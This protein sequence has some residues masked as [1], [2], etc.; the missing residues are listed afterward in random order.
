MKTRKILTTLLPSLLMSGHAMAAGI[1]V[2]VDVPD[3]RGDGD[4]GIPTINDFISQNPSSGLSA[5]DTFYNSTGGGNASNFG[6]NFG[7]GVVIGGFTVTT[8]HIDGL[9]N[10][11]TN[12][13]F[14]AGDTSHNDLNPITEGYAF[15]AAGTIVTFDGL[16]VNSSVGDTITLSIWGIGDNISQE[17]QFTVTYGG[18]LAAEGNVQSTLYNG[19][20]I[21]DR[22]DAT[23]SIPFVNFTFVADGVTDDISFQIDNGPGTGNATLNGFSLTVVPEPSSAALLGLGFMGLTLRRRR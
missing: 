1:A 13:G 22:G 23:G 3:G 21:T 20:T 8:S 15:A 11:G 5:S 10:T 16:L 19:A 7:G 14:N 4:A 2:N 18:N 6:S 9:P 12:S 17:G